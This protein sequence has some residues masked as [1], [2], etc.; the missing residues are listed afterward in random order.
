MRCGDGH[1]FEGWFPS[2][3]AFDT[4]AQRGLLSCPQCG[5]SDVTRALM[6]PAV[7]T[8]PA[9]PPAP[10]GDH[11]APTE[12]DAAM[13]ATMRAALQRLRQEVEQR[14]EDV[15]DR[16]AEEALRIHRGETEEHGIYGNATEEE[17]ERLADEGVD[18]ISVPWVR[19]ADS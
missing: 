3:H 1:G 12:R 16:F 18:I 4:Q 11:A 15:G 19:R 17:R 13:P 9:T 8:V 6:A 5:A 7:R 2:S 14:C 10:A